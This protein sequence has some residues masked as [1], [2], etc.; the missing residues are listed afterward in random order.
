M[1]KSLLMIAESFFRHR[2]NVTEMSSDFFKPST[3]LLVA[4]SLKTFWIEFSV[5]RFAS[6]FVWIFSSHIKVISRRRISKALAQRLALQSFPAIDKFLKHVW[7]SFAAIWK[8]INSFSASKKIMFIS[9][10]HR[11]IGDKGKYTEIQFFNYILTCQTSKDW[12][13]TF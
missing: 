12:R 8:G 13:L 11:G 2:F 5:S 6:K 1:K 7:D 4:K 9:S 3:S 10:S